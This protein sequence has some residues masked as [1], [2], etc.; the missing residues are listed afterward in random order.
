MLRK[1]TENE[2]IFKLHVLDF[3]KQNK[4]R[5]ARNAENSKTDFFKIRSKDLTFSYYS[6]NQV[7]E[8]LKKKRFSRQI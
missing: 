5:N 7:I 8:V 2:I 6:V 1:L 4:R 3:S